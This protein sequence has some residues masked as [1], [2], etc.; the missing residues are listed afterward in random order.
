MHLEISQKILNGK[1][2]G[3][4]VD[5]LWSRFWA[6]FKILRRHQVHT[7]GGDRDEDD[8]TDLNGGESGNIES[9]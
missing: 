5:N 6:M 2:D 3:K 1:H 4:A 9:V 8:G 7:A